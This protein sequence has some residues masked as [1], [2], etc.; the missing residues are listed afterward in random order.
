[1]HLTDL[2]DL[3][4]LGRRDEPALEVRGADGRLRSLTFGEIDVRASR[5]AHAQPVATA[6]AA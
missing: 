5:M 6:H 1:M 4:L 2:F 3:S